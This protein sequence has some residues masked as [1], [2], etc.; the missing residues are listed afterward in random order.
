MT[1]V[2]GHLTV[3]VLGGRNLPAITI[4][5][6]RVSLLPDG[7]GELSMSVV[8]EGSAP[9]HLAFVSTPDAART[10]WDG[11]VSPAGVELVT[12]RTVTLGRDGAPRLLLHGVHD[13]HAGHNVPLILGFA[14]VGLVHLQALPP[15]R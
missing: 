11:D 2:P 3:K 12:G 13:I 4:A 6:A 7:D 14:N 15:P 5:H 1:S 8:N 9:E 10:S